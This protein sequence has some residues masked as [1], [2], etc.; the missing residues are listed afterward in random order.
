MVSMTT[1]WVLVALLLVSRTHSL[2]GAPGRL[3]KASHRLLGPPADSRGI[4]TPKLAAEKGTEIGSVDA[5]SV[6]DLGSR[7]A[8]DVK[9]TLAWVAAAAVFSL[10]VAG[11]MGTQEAIEFCSGYVLEYCLSVDNLFVF[12]VLFDYFN[13]KESAMR[14]KVL[15]YGIWGAVILRGLF[16][17]AGAAALQQSNQIYLLFAG[18]LAFSSFKIL[19]ASGEEDEEENLDNNAIVNLTKSVFRTSSNFNGDNFF[20]KEDGVNMVTPLLLCLVCVE[21]SDVVFAFDS[22]PA[23]FG[24][25]NNPFIVFTSN[26]FAIAG[27]R[28]LFGVLSQAV[29]DLEYLEKAVGLVLAVISAKLGAESFDYELLNP[30]QSLVVV[31]TILGA[32]IGASLI[33]DT[34]EE[35]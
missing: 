15:G 18:V 2:R 8:D 3:P 11:T 25:T 34:K 22:V 7:Y 6:D 19:F 32:G 12:L 14:E 16:V 9:R 1:L 29:A 35:R 4:L 31:L 27:L 26:M 28:S 30:L 21:L 33:K 5:K 24:V 13:V 23:V 17:G 20:I 10:G